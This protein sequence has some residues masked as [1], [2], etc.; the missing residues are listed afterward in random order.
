M[1]LVE[2][3][4]E[5]SP[6]EVILPNARVTFSI[7]LSQAEGPSV[8]GVTL[9]LAA[10]NELSWVPLNSRDSPVKTTYD[11]VTVLPVPSAFVFTRQIFGPADA[12]LAFFVVR[13][14]I[15]D[16]HELS[17]ALPVRVAASSQ[18]RESL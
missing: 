4:L 2:S 6:A 16:N 14:T 12:R 10:D 18:T 7:G 1:I 13:M 15:D 9:S 5:C 8:H 17:W 3:V 11:T